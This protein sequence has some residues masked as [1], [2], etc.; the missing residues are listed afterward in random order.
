MA[1]ETIDK[2]KRQPMKWDKIFANDAYDK[3]LIS[4][5]Y[6]QLIQRN[7]KYQTIQTKSSQKM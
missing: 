2:T 3:G 5:T 6:K 4:R 7:T 1:K